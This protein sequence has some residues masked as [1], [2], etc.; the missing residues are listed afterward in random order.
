MG[1][2]ICV[3]ETA[4]KRMNGLQLG[5]SA[6]LG[7]TRPWN[8]LFNQKIRDGMETK[9]AQRLTNEAFGYPLNWSPGYGD[10]AEF[11]Q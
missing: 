3:E 9:E 2:V 6:P 11:G 7:I 8:D 4:K 1:S 5:R 10:P